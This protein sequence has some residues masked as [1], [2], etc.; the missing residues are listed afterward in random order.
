MRYAYFTALFPSPSGRFPGRPAVGDRGSA[1]SCPSSGSVR[2]LPIA[3]I[4][5][6]SAP[7]PRSIEDDDL[8]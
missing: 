7:F 1:R 2:P 3:A 5:E 8:S 4:D 6:A